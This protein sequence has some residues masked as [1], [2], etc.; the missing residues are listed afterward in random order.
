M[1]NAWSR[2]AC[3]CARACAAAATLIL[4]LPVLATNAINLVSFGA[5]SSTMGGADVALV[6]DT[7]ALVINPAGLSR[8]E[9]RQLQVDRKS[10]V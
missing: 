1:K 6:R 2:G 10:V 5:E 9:D 8:I 3:R 7:A 4:S